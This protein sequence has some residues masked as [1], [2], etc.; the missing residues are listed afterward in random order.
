[1]RSG[2][3]AHIGVAAAAALAGACLAGGPLYVSSAASEAVQVGLA[4]TCLTDA[5]LVVRLARSPSGPE[6]DL[7]DAAS[8]T[9]NAQAAIVTETVAQF[10]TVAG[11]PSSTRVVLLDRTR[12][13]DELG[14]PPLEQGQALAPDWAQRVS[15]LA[16]G[17]SVRGEVPNA[18]PPTPYSLDVRG[19]YPGIPVNPEPSYWCGVR[20]LL[21]PDPFGDPPPP[22]LVVDSSTLGALPTLNLSRIVEV[23]PDPHGLT[24]VEA[25]RLS[26]ALDAMATTYATT[27]TGAPSGGPIGIPIRGA[28]FRDGLPAIISYAETLSHVVGRTVAP[29]RLAGL[30]AAG[31]LLATAGA[32]LARARSSELRLRVLR[33]VHPA[34]VGARVA[35]AAAPAVLLGLALGFVLA[36]VAVTTLGPTPELE[37][38]PVRAA[39][40]ACLLGAIAGVFVVGVVTTVLSARS[41]DARP[42]HHW[43][44]WVPW[45]LALVALAVASYARLDRAGGVRLVGASAQGGDLLAQAFPLLALGAVLAL[46][47]RPSRWLLDRSRSHW[48][49][50]PVPLLVGARRL[51]ADPTVTVLAALA[52]A[53][54]I[55]SVTMAS[56]LTDSANA[57]LRQKASTYLGSDVAVSV[58]EVETLPA[59]LADRATIVERASTHSGDER[60][61][62]IGVDPD[63]F[64]RANAQRP[65]DRDVTALLSRL[66]GGDSS[67]GIA[68]IV[69]H[70]SL[71]SATLADET[72]S[73]ITVSPVASASWFPGYHN[74]AT[75]VVVDRRLLDKSDLGRATEVWIHDPPPNAVEALQASGWV[76][77]GSQT[78]GDVFDATSFLTVRWS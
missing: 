51:A 65:S 4:R 35:A 58:N 66:G 30:A 67:D 54:V 72:R 41:V 63:T 43:L 46:L 40:V 57:M 76:V 26:R 71:P 10:V 8:R 47:A 78:I 37:P 56:T 33:G 27:A 50:L 39:V 20:T 9:P 14:V 16:A 55:G 42:R 75:M 1:M 60:V 59:S 11:A 61:D 38:G 32:L 28:R 13:Y 77:L 62:L 73:T 6:Q 44:R 2:V 48:R 22:M 21:R 25:K 7:V 15:G 53:L 70:G 64:V 17:V 18:T 5:G 52:I 49:H 74:G 3:G 34:R 19:V 45:E 12:Q 24:R 31:L 68:A 36:L 29:V 69:V 23:R